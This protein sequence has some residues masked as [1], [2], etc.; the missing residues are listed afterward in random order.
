MSAK[1]IVEK[2]LYSFPV[3]FTFSVL[4]AWAA[5]WIFMG[6]FPH[7]ALVWEIFVAAIP[8]TLAWFSF[9]SRQELSMRQMALRH[10]I[11]F[12]LIVTILLSSSYLWG[13]FFH[14]NRLI[15]SA[16][17]VVL[18]VIVYAIVLEMEFLRSKR[19]ASK[20]MQRVREQR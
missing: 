1:E 17:L 8:I 12:L 6:K 13:W 14:E 20:L 3:I 19:L 5:S 2:I 4:G 10:G 16:V 15:Q 7:S 18:V 9:Y 11:H